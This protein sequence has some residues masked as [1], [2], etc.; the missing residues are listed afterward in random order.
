MLP[1]AA[2]PFEIQP[3][4]GFVVLGQC[5]EGTLQLA[6][7]DTGPGAFEDSLGTSRRVPH[8]TPVVFSP[9]A[10]PGDWSGA[11]E[12]QI[13]VERDA[14]YSDRQRDPAISSA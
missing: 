7:V 1:P 14:S 10:G 4:M 2:A 3:V 9:A 8:R 11:F 6:C 5:S 12:P 13:L